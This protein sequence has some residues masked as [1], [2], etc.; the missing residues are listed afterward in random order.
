MCKHDNMITKAEPALPSRRDGFHGSFCLPAITSFIAVLIYI[1]VCNVVP[2]AC[3]MAQSLSACITAHIFTV[4]ANSLHL[5]CLQSAV[6]RDAQVL[7]KPLLWHMC[8]KTV[9]PKEVEAPSLMC[10]L[11]KQSLWAHLD[12]R[13]WSYSCDSLP[14]DACQYLRTPRSKW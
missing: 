11:E 12:W 4:Q 5:S 8:M 6:S 3:A 7:H 10:L 1:C 14:W 9:C 13:D 2:R